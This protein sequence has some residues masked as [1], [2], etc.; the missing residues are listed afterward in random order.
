MWLGHNRTSLYQHLPRSSEYGWPYCGL[1]PLQLSSWLCHSMKRVIFHVK[2]Y[3]DLPLVPL[4]KQQRPSPLLCKRSFTPPLQSNTGRSAASSPTSKIIK[5]GWL[6]IW[7]GREDSI[8]DV[9]AVPRRTPPSHRLQLSGV[10][11]TSSA[12]RVPTLCWSET[13]SVLDCTVFCHELWE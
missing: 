8:K 1:I 9:S 10:P 13:D 4:A 5:E 2:Q 3:A 11:S 12:L 7:P 6:V